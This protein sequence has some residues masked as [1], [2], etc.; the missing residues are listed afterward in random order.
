MN[1]DIIDEIYKHA[2]ESYP[3]ECCGVVI[4]KG[5]TQAVHR[6][7]NIQNELHAA[8]PEAHPRDARTAYAIN[9]AE[10]DKIY[11]EARENG[12]EVIAFYHSH[13]D[14]DAYFSETDKAAQAA[15][16]EPEFPDAVQIVVS[17]IK[18]NICGLKAFKWDK[19]KKRFHL[20]SGLIRI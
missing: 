2:V 12:K 1:K 19:A 16:G 3:D 11:A 15:F 7:R 5:G 8:D 17:V 9:R 6:C 4:G 10:A 20:F 14:C 18:K 13:I